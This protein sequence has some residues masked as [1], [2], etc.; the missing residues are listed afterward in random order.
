MGLKK[1]AQPSTGN[2]EEPSGQQCDPD[3]VSCSA[4]DLRWAT[5]PIPLPSIVSTTDKCDQVGFGTSA[6]YRVSDTS[7]H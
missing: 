7:Q 5:I 6:D 1:D 4:V 3:A 2:F